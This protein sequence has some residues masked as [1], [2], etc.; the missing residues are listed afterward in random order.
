[1]IDTGNERH[2]DQ[3]SWTCKNPGKCQTLVLTVFLST[4]LQNKIKERTSLSKWYVFWYVK[5]FN[6]LLRSNLLQNLDLLLW[7]REKVEQMEELWIT[8]TYKIF[9]SSFI[10][11]AALCF[12]ITGTRF[13]KFVMLYR[14]TLRIKSF[15]K[16]D[17]PMPFMRYIHN[18]PMEVVSNT[19]MR[20]CAASDH[21]LRS[22]H[23]AVHWTSTWCFL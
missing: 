11:Q 5:T 23:S 9:K 18:V 7:Y 6:R 17:I 1:M 10:W 2:W 13:V 19:T 22:S 8:K 15:S 3:D 21:Y 14:E 4:P 16:S 20:S 12:D